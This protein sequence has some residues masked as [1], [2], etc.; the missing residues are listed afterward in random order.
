MNLQAPS[1]SAIQVIIPTQIQLEVAPLIGILGTPLGMQDAPLVDILGAAVLVRIVADLGFEYLSMARPVPIQYR[2]CPKL[3]SF[4]T[5]IR[6]CSFLLTDLGYIDWSIMLGCP[7]V[8]SIVRDR[9]SADINV[10]QV[11]YHLF[12]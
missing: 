5:T 6:M 8:V 7:S 12:H 11:N 10:P 9:H 1:D 2:I 3:V 4:F